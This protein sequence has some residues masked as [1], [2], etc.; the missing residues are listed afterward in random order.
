ML[1]KLKHIVLTLVLLNVFCIY[2]QTGFY[3]D[4]AA[5]YTESNTLMYVEGDVEIMNAG[6]IENNGDIELTADWINNAG[7]S[8]LINNRPGNV[9]L[10][11]GNQFIAGNS[12]TEFYNLNLLGGFSLKETFQDVLVTNQL[13]IENAELQVHQN[14]FHVTNPDPTTSV[15]WNSGL[16]SGDSIGG[17]FARSTDR[18][19]IYRFPV[20]DLSLPSSQ[21]RGVDVTPVNS[22]STV[23]G[24]RLAPV[25]ASLDI[26]GTS[27]TGAPGPYDRTLKNPAIVDI[28]PEFYHHIVRMYGTTAADIR[29]YFYEVDHISPDRRLDG[30]AQWNYG[31]PRWENVSANLTANIIGPTDIGS[32]E[33]ALSWTA[34][35]FLD[36]AFALDVLQGDLAFVPQI[37]SPN[38]DGSNDILFV[39]G[40]KVREIRF[41]IYNRWGEKVF[42]STDKA[43][44]WNGEYKS[45]EAQSG[46]YVYYLDAE[47]EDYGRLEMKGN[48][49]LV[50]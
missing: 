36:D 42:E 15:L 9:N 31:A 26:T 21:Y 1:N 11:G 48:V 16:I 10:I 35:N 44:G 30:V 6:T 12:V 45:K 19:S 23:F 34:S 27:F 5:V 24:V 7:N 4:N 32:P 39:R 25:D 33:H 41:I 20:G 13:D 46:V 40:S 43:I 22:D 18:T 14:T 47:I 3:V 2:S 50:R 17:Y 29:L 38:G 8:G 37:F 28:N 49:T